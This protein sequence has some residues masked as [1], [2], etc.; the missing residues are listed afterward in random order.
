M[1][2]YLQFLSDHDLLNLHQSG[3]RHNHSTATAVIDVTDYIL[4]KMKNN[5]VGAVF[6]D[7]AEAFD[8]IDHKILDQKLKKYGIRD[9][10]HKWFMSYLSGRQ[11]LTIVN[12]KRSEQ[13]P[14]KT[15]WGPTG[16]S[17]GS[18]TIPTVHK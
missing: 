15:L 10:E 12:D 11:Q 17:T 3:F 16:V 1:N 6:L 14:E 8:S 2:S 5:Y 13:L 7:L 18:C 4:E 9:T